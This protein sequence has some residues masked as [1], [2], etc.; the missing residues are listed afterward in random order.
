MSRTLTYLLRH[1]AKKEG[2]EIT[3]DGYISVP[4]L[5]Y[6][7]KLKNYDESKLLQIVKNCPKQRFNA[8]QNVNQPYWLLLIRPHPSLL[9]FLLF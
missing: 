3:N 2:L 4:E 8:I 7:P 5:L 6:Y 9:P 1:G